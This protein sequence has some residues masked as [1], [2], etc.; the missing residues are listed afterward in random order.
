MQ[1]N[2][3]HLLGW[4]RAAPRASLCCADPHGE[5]AVHVAWSFVLCC[6]R[7][8]SLSSHISQQHAG[9][10]AALAHGDRI[11][12]YHLPN[13]AL[14]PVVLATAAC[15]GTISAMCMARGHRGAL[16]LV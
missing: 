2:Q 13:L 9:T 12:I 7:R 6:C 3:P 5:L 16:T 8:F 1:L 14:P 4:L 11:S 15:G 10:Y